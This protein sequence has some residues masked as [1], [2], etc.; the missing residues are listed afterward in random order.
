LRA[1][2]FE[3]SPELIGYLLSV[4]PAQRLDI[5]GVGGGRSQRLL[6]IAA[7]VAPVTAVL[8]GSAVGLVAALINTPELDGA[9]RGGAHARRGLSRE[10]PTQASAPLGSGGGNRQFGYQG[11]R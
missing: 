6:T 4:P 2:Y 8:L 3:H 10:N 5:Q 11:A 1:Y 9:A 7:M